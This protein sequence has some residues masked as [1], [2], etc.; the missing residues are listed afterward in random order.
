MKKSKRRKDPLGFVCW[1]DRAITVSK[2]F[3]GFEEHIKG[4][5]VKFQYYLEFI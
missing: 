5:L 4:D 1:D 3:T 2:G